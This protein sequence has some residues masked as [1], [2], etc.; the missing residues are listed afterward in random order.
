MNPIKKYLAAIG[1]R[2]GKAGIGK[3]KAR[4]KA[5]ASSA[6]RAR[7]GLNMVL[8]G[9]FRQAEQH[10]RANGWRREDWRYVASVADIQGC[11]GF[12]LHRVGTWYDRKDRHEIETAARW[13]EKSK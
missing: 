13:R 5:Q 11:D 9:N 3:A 6:A 12:K 10:A 2:G 4:T 1:S 7:W 8:A